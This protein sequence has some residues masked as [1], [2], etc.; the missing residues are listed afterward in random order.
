MSHIAKTSIKASQDDLTGVRVAKE[1][2]FDLAESFNYAVAAFDENDS[3]SSPAFSYRLAQFDDPMAVLTGAKSVADI[4][5][6]D[7]DELRE[8][9]DEIA[10]KEFG[11]ARITRIDNITGAEYPIIFVGCDGTRTPRVTAPIPATNEALLND[12]A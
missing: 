12:V 2:L 6:D 1:S 7:L 3:E 5:S 11:C 9:F 4:I 10:S 8:K